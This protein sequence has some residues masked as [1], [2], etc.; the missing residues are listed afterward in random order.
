MTRPLRFNLTDRSGTITSGGTAQVL[1]AENL[2][3]TGF[4]IQNL[5]TGDLWISSITTAVASQPSLKI[6]AGGL[7]ECP[8]HGVPTNAISIIGAIT[9]QA[10]QAMEW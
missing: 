4:S 6:P 8:L 7:Y 5:S 3:R 9:G 2:T 1:M 10:F